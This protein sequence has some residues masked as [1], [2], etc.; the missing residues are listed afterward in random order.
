MYTVGLA[1]KT[2]FNL[3]F[4]FVFNHFTVI[5][6]QNQCDYL[7]IFQKTVPYTGTISHKDLVV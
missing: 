1:N 7:H 4:A 2:D 3:I 5:L 6:F